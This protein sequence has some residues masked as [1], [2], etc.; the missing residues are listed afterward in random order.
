M[1]F[2]IIPRWELSDLLIDKKIY[3]LIT[4]LRSRWGSVKWGTRQMPGVGC[5]FQI[6]WPASRPRSIGNSL[7]S[8]RALGLLAALV[9]GFAG[10]GA[11]ANA[12]SDSPRS[13]ITSMD[14]QQRVEAL[15]RSWFAALANPAIDSNQLENFL[16]KTPFEYRSIDQVFRDR[17]AFLASISNLRA[18]HPHTEYQLGPIQ[19]E[20]GEPDLYQA[21][22]EFSTR[23]LDETG[24]AHVARREQVW[25]IRSRTNETP[26]ILRIEDQPLLVYPGTG[27]QIVCY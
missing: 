3:L 18:L 13:E 1:V 16:A 19:I 27:A 26:T 9:I 6:F 11:L 21:R 22:F 4:V 23:A 25:T 24:I 5:V 17:D 20:F 15:I 7:R 10:S 8:R 2:E 12:G 14:P